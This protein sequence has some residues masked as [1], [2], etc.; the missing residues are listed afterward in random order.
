MLGSVWLTFVGLALFGLIL[1]GVTF[2]GLG[3]IALFFFLLAVPHLT[4]GIYLLRGQ[5]HNPHRH[6]DLTAAKQEAEMRRGGEP[7]AFPDEGTTGTASHPRNER[8]STLW[9]LYGVE[10]RQGH[11]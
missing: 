10:S 1:E 2:S 7:L 6:A 11:R 8:D 4:P 9:P 3:V 5:G